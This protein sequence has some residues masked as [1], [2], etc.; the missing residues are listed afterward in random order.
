MVSPSQ[1]SASSSTDRYRSLPITS[2][3]SL[4]TH[5]LTGN[6]EQASNFDLLLAIPLFESNIPPVETVSSKV[7]AETP[8]SEDSTERSEKGE[9]SD[10]RDPADLTNAVVFVPQYEELKPVAKAEPLRE[11]RLDNSRKPKS[12]NVEAYARHRST[13]QVSTKPASQSPTSNFQWTDTSSP[14]S[15]EDVE[16]ETIEPVVAIQSLTKSSEP[17]N[18][19]IEQAKAQ[20]VDENLAMA[21]DSHNERVAKRDVASA[22]VVGKPTVTEV[23]PENPSP[24]F[25]EEQSVSEK[26]T[27]QL[28]ETIAESGIV[29]RN[30]RTERLENIR[31]REESRSDSQDSEKSVSITAPNESENAEGFQVD[32]LSLSSNS[33]RSPI[34]L[35]GAI[36][37]Q[38]TSVTTAAFDSFSATTPGVTATTGLGGVRET[39]TPVVTGSTE[40]TIGTVNSSAAVNG[41]QANAR[42]STGTSGS[43]STDRSSLTPYQEQ[44]VL[45]RVLRG[46]E[47]LANGSNQVRLRLHPPELGTLQVTIRIEAQ[48]VAGLIEVETVAARDVL[49]NNLPQLQA[50]LADQGLSVQQFEIRVVEPNQFSQGDQLGGAWNQGNQPGTDQ[51]DERRANN[52]LDR[53]RNRIDTPESDP[54]RP[55]TRLWTRTHGQIDLRV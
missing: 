21:D 19:E 40:A 33:E 54:S 30:R 18:S 13:E 25:F 15:K 38:P 32:L 31:N 36:D 37:A 28:D 53:L 34:E 7:E 46:M 6:L 24:P 41:G 26:S 17:D 27:D 1:A 4:R 48:Q 42:S 44:K 55:P 49:Q 45:Q 16:S 11:E 29:P 50:R 10:E 51:R 35:V 43:A 14:S 20:T 52:Y 12:E 47:Q 5:N 9:K 2:P 39:N 22:P 23:D 8:I 3:D